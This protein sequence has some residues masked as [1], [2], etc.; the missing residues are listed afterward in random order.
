[1]TMS[2]IGTC[3]RKGVPQHGFHVSGGQAERLKTRKA[4][5]AGGARVYDAPFGIA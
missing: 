4:H 3:R 2:Q 1:M 5:K